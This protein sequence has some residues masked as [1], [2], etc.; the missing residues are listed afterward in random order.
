MR[1]APTDRHDAVPAVRLSA[2]DAIRAVVGLGC[3]AAAGPLTPLP[4]G[5][6]HD[7]H[8]W[9]L[10]RRASHAVRQ[11]LTLGRPFALSSENQTW[12]ARALRRYSHL[13]VE[14]AGTPIA[15]RLSPWG[16]ACATQR[17]GWSRPADQQDRAVL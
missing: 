1:I 3:L 12:A 6:G 11:V 13:H 17:T 7:P 8:G 16:G 5:D 15:D 4:R 9:E 10:A 14:P 2:T